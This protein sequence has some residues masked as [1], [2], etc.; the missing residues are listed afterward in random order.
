MDHHRPTAIAIPLETWIAKHTIIR[1][2]FGHLHQRDLNFIPGK[3]DE[4]ILRF[5]RL[6]F[7]ARKAVVDL[8]DGI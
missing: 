5:Q 2:G 3:E 4:L 7:R 8:I 6:L 1:E